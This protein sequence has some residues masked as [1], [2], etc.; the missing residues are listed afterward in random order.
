M[1]K[2]SFTEKF[3]PLLTARA[4]GRGGRGLTGGLLTGTDPLY[5]SRFIGA[6][7]SESLYRAHLSVTAS[8]GRRACVVGPVS[9]GV[10]HFPGLRIFLSG[11][12]AQDGVVD[13]G[14]TAFFPTNFGHAVD[15]GAGIRMLGVL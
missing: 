7:L 14:Q 11:R 4:H 5:R 6:V 1:V 10:V 13:A 8:L 2:K 9:A 12:G 15:Q 3:T